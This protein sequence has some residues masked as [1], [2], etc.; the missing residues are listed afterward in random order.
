M[1]SAPRGARDGGEA[2]V[3]DY[4]PFFENVVVRVTGRGERER[5]RDPFAAFHRCQKQTK[6][7][8]QPEVQQ[9]SPKKK[10]GDRQGIAAEKV[11]QES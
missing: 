6:H 1:E 3:E 2:G 8:P 7:K 11:W 10:V 5:E 9:I 4:P